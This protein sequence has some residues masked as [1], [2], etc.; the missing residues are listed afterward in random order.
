[1]KKSIAS[2]TC[3]L[4]M[5]AIPASAA[6]AAPATPVSA[7]DTAWVQS[8]IAGNLGA[9]Q[10]AQLAESKSTNPA[11]LGLARFILKDHSRQLRFDDRLASRLNISI[12]GTADATILA[13]MNVLNTLTGKAFNLQFAQDELTDH[14]QFLLQTTQ[15]LNL[16]TNASVRGAA[17]AW[18]PVIQR[19]INLAKAAVAVF[20]S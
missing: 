1:M 17:H 11:I 7:T 18:V 15:E 4:A 16:G 12:P 8:A 6:A 9:V 5:A 2:L 10:A 3:A 20:S 19:R 13:Q 14:T